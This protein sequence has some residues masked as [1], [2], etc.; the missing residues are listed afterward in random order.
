MKTPDELFHNRFSLW[1]SDVPSLSGEK[2]GYVGMIE[3]TDFHLLPGAEE[4]L[5][6]MGC[7]TVV[8]PMEGNTWSKHRA[9]IA[10]NERPPFMLE[11]FTPPEVAKGF[12]DHGY[13]ILAEYSSSFID[14]HK[15][16]DSFAKIGTRMEKAGVQIRPLDLK[17]IEN[18]LRRIFQLSIRTFTNNFLYTPITEAEFL[19]MYLPLTPLLTSESAFLAEQDGEIIGFVFGYQEGQTMIVK[20]LAVLPERTF[21]GLGT[22][23]GHLFQQAAKKRGCTGAI[24][25]LQREDNQSLRIS[26]RFTAEVFRRYALFSKSL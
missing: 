15:E 6:D 13:S 4:R 3:P 18:E 25:A 21:A 7:T 10:S 5:R 12:Q 24:H 1:W 19:A 22:F 8:G 9:V 23:L 17:D 14:L 20:T 26:K 11:P 16:S 2:P